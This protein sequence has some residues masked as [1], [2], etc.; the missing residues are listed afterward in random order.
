MKRNTP[1]VY[2]ICR[3]D[4]KYWKDINEE[5]SE[6]GYKKVKAFIPSIKILKKSKAGKNIY[7]EVPYLFNYGFI[8]MKSEKAYDRQFLNKLKRDIPGILG[9]M[10]SPET[11]FPRKKRARIDNA[12]DFDD[13]SMVATVTK[14]EVKFY[15]NNAK[16]NQVF[17]ANDI[18][19]IQIGSYV[20]LR[21]YPF[22][23]IEATIDEIN[24]TT[25][26]VTVTLYPEKGSLVIQVPME[27][28]FYSVYQNY[29]EDI[30]LSPDKEIDVTQIPDGSTEEL[31]NSKQY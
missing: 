23:G 31:L 4:Q 9:F 22:E 21:G 2:C 25:K 6:R 26:M 28:V 24:L 14:E 18:T 3:I 15:K 13:F 19:N 11:M 17:S 27:N 16:K 5:L 1:Y 8:R 10:K 30:L 29:N 7:D 20:T 12:E